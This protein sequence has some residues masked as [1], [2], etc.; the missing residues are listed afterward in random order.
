MSAVDFH[1]FLAF[2]RANPGFRII[3]WTSADV[4][5]FGRLVEVGRCSNVELLLKN[6][7]APERLTTV[8]DW[9]N[10]GESCSALLLRKV[11]VHAEELPPPSQFAL[12][13]HF[14]VATDSVS[15]INCL[16]SLGAHRRTIERGFGKRSKIRLEPLADCCLIA[17]SWDVWLGGRWT[18]ADAVAG[19]AGYTRTQT[20]TDHYKRFLG[21]EFTPTR[22]FATLHSEQVAA[23]LYGALA[24]RLPG[25]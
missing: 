11:L 17:R 9:V 18:Q 23:M 19:E 4:Q 22:A 12:T 3:L 5:T 15:T 25:G 14:N 20:M 6:L 1:G 8:L 16:K 21:L 24:E 10:D 13:K 7:G 2:V